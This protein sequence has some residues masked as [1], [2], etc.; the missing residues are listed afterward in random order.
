[1]KKQKIKVRK[2]ASKRFKVTKTGKVMYG[3]QY[4]SHRKMNKSSRRLRRGSEP[5][6]LKGEFAKKIKM[7][8]GEA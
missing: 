6:E 1:M 3:H 5:A 8:L 7:M 2:S 4:Q